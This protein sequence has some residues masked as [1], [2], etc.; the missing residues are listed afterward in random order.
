MRFLTADRIRKF[1]GERRREVEEG[2]GGEKVEGDGGGEDGGREA[3]WGGE[4]RLGLEGLGEGWVGLGGGGEGRTSA[5]GEREEEGDASQREE[6]E[7]RERVVEK[8]WGD[9]EGYGGCPREEEKRLSRL[10]EPNQYQ[11]DVVD[12][13]SHFLVPPFSSRTPPLDFPAVSSNP[14]LRNRC[15][16]KNRV[17]NESVNVMLIAVIGV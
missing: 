1:R 4:G 7:K 15:S 12:F 16:S 17:R 11:N 2:L 14:A 5:S 3:G 13:F 6:R 8:G 10:S 9:G